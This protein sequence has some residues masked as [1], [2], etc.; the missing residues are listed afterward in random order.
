MSELAVYPGEIVALA[1]RRKALMESFEHSDERDVLHEH[2]EAR[3]VDTL[4]RI[5][6]MA[7]DATA[8]VDPLKLMRLL[9]IMHGLAEALNAP[10]WIIRQAEQEAR[11]A[12]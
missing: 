11:A 12:R 6:E 2:L 10:G 1:R 7:R 5:E 8:A 9:G 3:R 4:K